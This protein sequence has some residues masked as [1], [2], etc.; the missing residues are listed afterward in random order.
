ML[1][2][3]TNQADPVSVV[4]AGRAGPHRAPARWDPGPRTTNSPERNL[5]ARHRHANGLVGA[6]DGNL[7]RAA[8]PADAIGGCGRRRVDGRIRRIEV[9]IV[10]GIIVAAVKTEVAV[11]D[12][13]QVEQIAAMPECK[14]VELVR[15]V[16]AVVD[17]WSKRMRAGWAVRP[18]RG[19]GLGGMPAGRPDG[20][21]VCRRRP[22][23]YRSR[24]PQPR[25][26]GRR[27]ADAFAYASLLESSEP[28]P[29]RV[30]F[31]RSGF[32]DSRL[33]CSN[34]CKQPSLTAV[35]RQT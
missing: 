1:G 22:R 21:K 32:I 8:S 5:T 35:G 33:A 17:G 31:R 29:P 2:Q 28:W 27:Y 10:A 6:R 4:I 12:E 25:A 20:T 7:L 18:R 19:G 34:S 16:R 15:C 23:P 24:R 9:G 11:R 26:R 14:L 30:P 3:R 13:R